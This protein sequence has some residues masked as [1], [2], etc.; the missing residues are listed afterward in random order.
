MNIDAFQAMVIDNEAGKPRASIRMLKHSD[1]P[2]HDVLVEI[3]YSGLNY[4]DGFGISGRQKN[5]AQGSSHCR[6]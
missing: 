2:D 6:H 4:K 5:R 3:A 1:L